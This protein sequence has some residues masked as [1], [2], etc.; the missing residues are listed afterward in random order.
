M[1][2]TWNIMS[3]SL[4]IAEAFVKKD[5]WVVSFLYNFC[6]VTVIARAHVHRIRVWVQLES[7]FYER[8]VVILPQ[9]TFQSYSTYNSARERR[10]AP[11]KTG[12]SSKDV[13]RGERY[14]VNKPHQKARYE[15]RRTQ[16]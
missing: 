1:I 9:S 8:T 12:R 6:T 5:V 3:S 7:T 4:G 11:T 13:A 2:L 15:P 10:A 14:T 16:Q